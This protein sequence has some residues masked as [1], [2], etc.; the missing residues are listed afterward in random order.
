MQVQGSPYNLRLQ[1]LDSAASYEWR[2]GE[3]EWIYPQL[4]FLA[5]GVDT[6]RDGSKA[7]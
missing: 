1:L 2:N 7:R 4:Q 3:G 6:Y 5:L